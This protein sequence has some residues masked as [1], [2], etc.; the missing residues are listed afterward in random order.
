M[1]KTLLAIVLVLAVSRALPDL[2]RLRDFSWLRIW[3]SRWHGDG[4]KGA[5]PVL[6][7]PALVFVLCALI[8]SALDHVLF[9]LPLFAFAVIVLFFCVGPR[10]LESDIDAVLKAPDRDQRLAAAQGLRDDRDAAPPTL[11]A[12]SLVEAAFEAAL[13]RWFGVIFW[14]VVLGPA[15][16][17][18]YRMI[19]LIAKSAAFADL[20]DADQQALAERTLRI[21]DW[22]PAHLMA[23]TLALVS[24]FDAVMRTWRAYHAAGGKGYFSLDLGFLGALARSGVDADVVAGDGYATDVNDPLNELAD[25]RRVL[26]RIFFAWLAVLALMVLAGFTQ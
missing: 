22:A 7:L 10:E 11:E 2:A 18:G 4:A 8:Q 26:R 21:L 25:P 12:A 23:L 5:R 14:F 13:S 24:D 16:A 19:R 20:I 15:G 3:L 17:L 9:G 6:L 1:A